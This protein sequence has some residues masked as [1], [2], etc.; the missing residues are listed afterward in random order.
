METEIVTDEGERRS[1]EFTASEEGG[2]YYCEVHPSS[3]RGRVAVGGGDAGNATGENATAGNET[4]TEEPG[5][6][7]VVDAGTVVL[8]GLAPYWLGLAPAGLRGRENPTLRLREGAEYELVW[9]NLDGVEHDFHLMDGGGDDLAD[10]SS[11]EDVGDT[12]STT[13]E[14]TAGMA[15]YVCEFHLQSMRGAVEVV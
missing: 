10:T 6:P 1:V 4:T 2:T 3:M 12:H 11:R 13:F 5:P 14:A 7:P 8:G 15:E 9:M